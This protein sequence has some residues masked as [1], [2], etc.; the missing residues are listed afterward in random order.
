[1]TQRQTTVFVAEQQVVE[2]NCA[3]YECVTGG[4][5]RANRDRRRPAAKRLL[6]G[7]YRL[8]QTHVTGGDVH[9]K[10][11]GLTLLCSSH[12]VER[13]AI[14]IRYI[15]RIIRRGKSKAR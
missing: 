8:P 1:M 15:D 5:I 10:I 12:Q 4:I 2:G 6:K 13:H 14:R 11:T 7:W 3:Q 9:P